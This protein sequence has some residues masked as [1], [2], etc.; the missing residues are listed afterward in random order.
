MNQTF[1]ESTVFN[2][3]FSI[4]KAFF[5]EESYLGR[6]VLGTDGIC[7]TGWLH[8]IPHQGK[9]SAN[10]AIYFKS[11]RNNR[12]RPKSKFDNGR[13]AFNEFVALAMCIIDRNVDRGDREAE[14]PG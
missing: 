3:F 11:E 8:E 4:P 2:N 5:C 14:A 9:A 12:K 13:K 1:R 7:A 10:F 6:T